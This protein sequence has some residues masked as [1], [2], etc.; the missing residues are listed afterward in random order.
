M[1][2]NRLDGL[3]QGIDTGAKLFIWGD[4]NGHIRKRWLKCIRVCIGYMI[5]ERKMGL[6]I[7]YMIRLGFAKSNLFQLIYFHKEWQTYV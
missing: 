6:V 4:L 3:V 5:V 7:G 1:N 2:E